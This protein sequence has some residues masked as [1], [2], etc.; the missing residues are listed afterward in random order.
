MSDI[1]PVKFGKLL[2]DMESL[3]TNQK[4]IKAKIEEMASKLGALE[5]HKAEFNGVLRSV[6]WVA[7][8]ISGVVTAAYHYFTK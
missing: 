5:L 8:T 7:A 4:D 2:G 1:D 6:K 3:L